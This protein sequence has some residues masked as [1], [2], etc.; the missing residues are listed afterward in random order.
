MDSAAPSDSVEPM[1]RQAG[2]VVAAASGGGGG[3]GVCRVAVAQMTSV[4][5]TQ[6]N[7]E[8]CSRLAKVNPS[9]VVGGLVQGTAWRQTSPCPSSVRE[10]CE[11]PLLPL[12]QEAA[13][14]GAAMLFLPE[15][16]NF[17]GRSPAEVGMFSP[18]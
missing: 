12:L 13:A 11:R 5:S 16:F 4:G 9:R 17:L 14:G 2:A 8:T 6:A 3:S 18:Q 1:S 7:F 15:N 10:C